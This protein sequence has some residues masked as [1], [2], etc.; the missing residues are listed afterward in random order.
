MSVTEQASIYAGDGG[1]AVNVGD[2]T[3]LK[4]AVIDST[5]SAEKKSLTTG[6]LVMEDIHN[7]ATYSAKNYGMTIS[8]G[9]SQASG[10]TMSIPVKGDGSS[11]TYSAISRGIIKAADRDISDI[12]RDTEHAL[13]KL[14]KIFDK[15]KVEE[16]Q[17]LS[18]LISKEGFTLIGDL[19]VHKQKELLAK[20]MEAEKDGKKDL[21]KQYV[22]E[23]KEWS[24]G[25]SY[26][27]AL[28][29]AFGAIVSSLN[30]GN[31]GIGAAGAGLTEALQKELGKIK[32]PEVHKLAAAVIGAV[33]TQST[34]GAAVAMDGTTYNWLM[35]SDQMN[36]LNDYEWFISLQ[37][38]GDI[39]SAR[40]AFLEKAAYYLALN[41]YEGENSLLYGSNDMISKELNDSIRQHD[42]QAYDNKFGIQLTELINNLFA[43][44][45]NTPEERQRLSALRD[46][47]LEEFR[48]NG[49]VYRDLAI[50]IRPTY[51]DNYGSNEKP[52]IIGE[53]HQASDG[54]IYHIYSDGHTEVTND[55]LGVRMMSAGYPVEQGADGAWYAN[56]AWVPNEYLPKD[57][58]DIS[59]A[60]NTS[61]SFGAPESFKRL[62]PSS[63]QMGRQ[64]IE[65]GIIPDPAKM[66]SDYEYFELGAGALKFLTGAGGGIIDK[67]GNVYLF[68]EG[69]GGFGVGTPIFVGKGYGYV[70]PSWL[71]NNP[72]KTIIDAIGGSSY[73]ISG[74]SLLSGSVSKGYDGG[75]IN[76]EFGIITSAGT[77][78]TYRRTIFIGNIKDF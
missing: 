14:G 51:G 23:A 58:R 21:A 32:S 68:A 45:Y 44:Y 48:A 40:G 64:L 3:H 46:A 62:N 22:K 42:I 4:G 19:A 16:R 39:E 31:I 52:R 9:T 20:A 71:K 10:P 17:V 26:K 15:K 5:A 35:H 18:N 30:G 25:G 54:R 63:K 1:F 34:S 12:N 76:T 43:E 6:H 69:T 36:L 66:T 70:D 27:I 57:K 50:G 7:T 75:A 53:G 67:E 47:K 2:T 73:G 59:Q 28:H 78:F 65:E 61:F 41:D 49:R 33:A 24:D 74:S 56:G 77:N 37:Q 29:S 8:K 60:F 13:N 55:W 38:G 72:D 11:V